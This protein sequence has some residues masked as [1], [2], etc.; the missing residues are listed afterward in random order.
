MENKK[1]LPPT[2]IFIFGGSGDLANRKLIPALFNLYLDKY[3]PE[4]FAVVG[5]GRT[6]FSSDDE[7]RNK[8]F[9]GVQQF[10]RRKGEANVSQKAQEAAKTLADYT[11]ITSGAILATLRF[12]RA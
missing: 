8:L 9:E 5:V 3:L 4:K 10:S 6:A 1:S 11:A 2:I 12:S 7:Y